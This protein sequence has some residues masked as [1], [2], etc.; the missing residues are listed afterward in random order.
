M[1]PGQVRNLKKLFEAKM[2]DVQQP[3]GY[4]AEANESETEFESE[5]EEE[6]KEKAVR[7]EKWKTIKI[8]DRF[9]IILQIF[10]KR[11]TLWSIRSQN[12]RVQASNRTK[13]PKIHK[14]AVSAG[15]RLNLQL[16]SQPIL[17]RPD[18]RPVSQPRN[19]Q[20]QAAASPRQYVGFRRVPA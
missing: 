11:G 20:R 3:R 10:A 1:T 13:L 15:L 9:S 16:H 19:R 4:N 7:K 2:N 17:G 12:P 18:A 6:R 5:T 8:F 14:N